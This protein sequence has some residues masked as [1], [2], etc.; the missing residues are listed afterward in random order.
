MVQRLIYFDNNSTTQVDKRV[1]KAMQPFFLKEYGNASS[2]HHQFGWHA[3]SAIESARKQV[4]QLI[5]SHPDEIVF[6]SGGTESNN[7]AIFGVLTSLPP[8]RSHLI[9]VKTEHSSVLE[10][11]KNW[12][13]SGH[14]VTLLNVDSKGLI[15]M[16]ELRSSITPETG[17]VSIMLVNNEIGVIQ[18]HEAIT[19]LCRAKGVLF[20]TDAAQGLGKVPLDVVA[21]NVDLASFSAHKIYGPKGVGALYVSRSKHMP[22]LNPLILGGGQELGLRSGTPNTPGIVGMGKACEIFTNEGPIEI[23][24][25]N[26]LQD[27]LLQGL[28]NNIGD[29]WINGDEHRRVS[30]NLNVSFAGVDVEDLLLRITDI[31]VSTGSACST[32]SLRPSHVLEALGQNHERPF[33][34]I[35]FSLGRFNT[36]DEVDYVVKRLKSEVELLRNNKKG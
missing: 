22:A 14:K 12:Q 33:A 26:D 6:T 35:R 29:L 3:E 19:K 8:N 10:P 20:H 30:G 13:A 28:K 15:D 32:S 25:I 36:A 23:Q 5:G 9:S 17:L 31:A 24:R 18:D 34:V 11:C 7:M 27:L 16:N 1:F 4:A 2:R 21:S